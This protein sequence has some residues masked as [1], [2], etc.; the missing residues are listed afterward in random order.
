MMQTPHQLPIPSDNEMRTGFISTSSRPRP[1]TAAEIDRIVRALRSIGFDSEASVEI[2][3]DGVCVLRVGQ[4]R[5]SD[6]GEHLSVEE[7]A[8]QIDREG[9]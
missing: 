4:N 7:L 9:R 1:S 5:R 8:A 2:R 6:G 3:S